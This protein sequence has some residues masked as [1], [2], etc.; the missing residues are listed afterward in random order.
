MRVDRSFGT[1]RFHLA[2]L[3]CMSTHDYLYVGEEQCG[4]RLDYNCYYHRKSLYLG[5]RA[6]TNNG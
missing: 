3:I 6:T 1:T 4:I 5:Y 2:S